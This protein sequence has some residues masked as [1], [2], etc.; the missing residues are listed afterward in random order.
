LLRAAVVEASSENLA[1]LEGRW[2]GRALT[3]AQAFAQ[4][5]YERYSHPLQVTFEYLRPHSMQQGASTAMAVVT[6]LEVWTYAGRSSSHTESFEFIYTLSRQGA[7]WVI[8]DYTYRNAPTL[9]PSATPAI[10][11]PITATTTLTATT[12]ITPAVP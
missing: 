5:L 7:D 1:A 9:Q 10:T 6:S 2:Q 8:T 3:K 4:D 11:S 12:A